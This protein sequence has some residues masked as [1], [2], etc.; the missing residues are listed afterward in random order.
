MSKSLSDQLREAI[1]TCGTTRYALAQQL[2]ISES[3]LS[4]F[5]G[6]ERGL[7]LEVI[8]KLA[9]VLGLQLISTVQKTR[10]PLPR[11]R[12]PN[13]ESM[14]TTTISL[15]GKA[16]AQF[17]AKEAYE[18]YSERRRGLWYVDADMGV[19]CFYD[20][21]PL[22]DGRRDLIIAK[23]RAYLRRQGLMEMSHATYPLSGRDAGNTY[24]MLIAGS[25]DDIDGIQAAVDA[26]VMKIC[27]CDY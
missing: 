22:S 11:G 26:A 8:D 12:R 25:E 2:H 19:I 17:F 13:E 6:G 7:T 16:Q 10:R 4:R 18:N 1:I 24:A 5:V 20:N 14:K 21:Y 15:E 9:D 23:L 27:F 3:A